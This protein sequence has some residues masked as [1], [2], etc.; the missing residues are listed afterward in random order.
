VLAPTALAEREALLDALRGFAVLGILLVNIE[1]MRGSDWLVLMG[2]GAVPPADLAEGIV[3]FTVG[4]LATAKFISSLAILFGVGAG[5]IASRSAASGLP[6]RPLLARRYLALMVFGAVHMLL[7]PGDVLFL[8]GVTGFALLAFIQLDVR[9]LL[10]VSASLLLIF[11][12]LALA[13]RWTYPEVDASGAGDLGFESATG[14]LREQTVAAYAQGTFADIV[15]AHV[16]QAVFLQSG[17]L[18][19][20]PWIL[21]LFLFGYAVARAGIAHRLSERHTLLRRGALIGLAVGLP[22]NVG[23]GFFGA[24]AGFGARPELHAPLLTLWA[25]AG[26]TL[27]APVLATGYLC[28]LALFLAR[29][30]TPHALVAVGRMT[31]T[32]YLFQSALALAIFG[33]LRLYDRLSSTS[34]LIVVAAVW[35][36]TLWLCPLWLRHFRIG[37]AEWLWRSLTYGGWQPLRRSR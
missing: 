16:S 2:G 28:A 11:T 17:Q 13:Y 18:F 34:A 5:L 36:L 10:A 30:G 35:A 27:G 33:G 21:A 19:A 26:Q 22:A 7:F 25:D 8:Y 32:A 12:G 31:L 4:W 3:Q 15:S 9:A 23:V 37:P 29:R 20:V 6:A 24:L 14:A 1:V